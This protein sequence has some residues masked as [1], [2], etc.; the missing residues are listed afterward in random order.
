[1]SKARW[2][3]L[4]ILSVLAL[5]LIFQNTAP[6]T[7]N[8]FFFHVTAPLVLLILIC[9]VIGFFIGSFVSLFKKEPK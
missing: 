9:L 6:A 8:I 5:I 3:I 1:M 7:V 2:I 4:L